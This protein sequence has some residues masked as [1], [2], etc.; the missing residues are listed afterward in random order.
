MMKIVY[1]INGLSTHGGVEVITLRKANALAEIEGNEI[2]IVTDDI[3]HIWIPL[4]KNVHLIELNVSMGEKSKYS[5]LELFLKNRKRIRNVKRKLTEILNEI[6]PDIVISVRRQDLLLLPQLKI[7]SRPSIIKE[8]HSTR[9]IYNF[10]AKKLFNRIYNRFCFFRENYT[11]KRYDKVV[12]LSNQE[13]ELFKE[14]TNVVTIP[15]I[16]TIPK[17]PTPSTLTAHKVITAGRLAPEKQQ[18]QL[19]KAWKIIHDK[20]PDW[21]LEIYGDGILRQKLNEQI[22][23]SGLENNV[24]LKGN[25]N[26]IT[27]AYTESS[28]F[29]LTSQSE[30]FSLVILEAM[31]CGLPIVSYDCPTGPREIISDGTDGF[32]VRQNDVEQ[33]AEKICYLIEQENVRKTMGMNARKTS[34]KYNPKTICN[35]WMDLFH[36]LRKDS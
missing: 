13:K 31:A 4:N 17:P 23:S 20:H 34:E 7:C 5:P 21:I 6:K 27:Q 33:L 10:K 36:Q 3:N 9:F 14:F 32:L 11:L 2:Y 19:V 35:Q 24:I 12:V 25:V 28:I 18:S 26:N 22:I 8:I 16:L 1:C 15:N 30:G 29:A